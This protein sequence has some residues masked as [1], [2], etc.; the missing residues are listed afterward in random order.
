MSEII[1][2]NV[3]NK[4]MSVSLKNSFETN[5]FETEREEDYFQNQLKNHYEHGYAEGQKS[6][7]E[8]LEKEYSEKLLKKFND[9]Q[10]ILSELDLK[11]ISYSDNFEKVVIN[12][13][14]LIAE[15]LVR[16]E[17]VQ[18]NII[19]EVLQE[20][21]KRVLGANRIVVKVN[22]VDLEILNNDSNQLLGDDSFAK[23]K[24]EPD[25]K[26]EQ[27]GCLVETEIG[28]VDAR[29]SSQLNEVKKQLEAIFSGDDL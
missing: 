6:A 25:S 13:A 10:K 17:L 28:N 20:S 24:F 7:Q 27:G 5:D 19:P 3:K 8:K 4:K 11:M 23:I 18:K 22:P 12:L 21:L 9:V 29:V 26:I 14:L 2:L 16:R 1:K 15:K